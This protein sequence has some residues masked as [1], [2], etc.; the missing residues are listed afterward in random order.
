MCWLRL[1]TGA[2]TM[3]SGQFPTHLS[4]VFLFYMSFT[5][6]FAQLRLKM[7]SCLNEWTQCTSCLFLQHTFTTMHLLGFKIDPTIAYF[8]GR[9]KDFVGYHL[10]TFPASKKTF[11]YMFRL[12]C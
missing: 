1:A 8:T 6:I 5:I 7:I 9:V 11:N 3:H 4:S 2:D 10:T 12:I